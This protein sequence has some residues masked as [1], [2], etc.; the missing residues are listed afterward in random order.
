MV[1]TL[2]EEDF[3]LKED[4]PS[5]DDVTIEDP[6]SFDFDPRTP[7]PVEN[8]GP[9]APDKENEGCDLYL[10]SHKEVSYTTWSGHCSRIPT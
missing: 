4:A 10:S 3:P 1:N 5:K 2:V 8:S 7:H 9:S 6:R